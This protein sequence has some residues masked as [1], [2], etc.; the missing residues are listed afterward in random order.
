[1]ERNR[2]FLIAAFIVSL[3]VVI[4][5]A[6]FASSFP[7]GLERVAED[8]GFIEKASDS[9]IEAVF[10]DY[11]ATFARTP[12]LRVI[13]PGVFGV[14]VTFLVASGAGLVLMK[15]KKNGTRVS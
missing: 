11:E 10:P 9:L 4:V 15:A 2:K 14:A 8:K 6:P 12:Y 1:M 7:D 3:L 13:I 5:L